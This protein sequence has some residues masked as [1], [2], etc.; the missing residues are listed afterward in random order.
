MSLHTTRA[1]CCMQWVCGPYL[2]LYLH[3][4]Q[5][6]FSCPFKSY[7]IFAIYCITHW[8]S[9]C[10]TCLHK[11]F[12]KSDLNPKNVIFSFFRSHDFFQPPRTG[13]TTVPRALQSGCELVS[14][15]SAV[16][17][18]RKSVPRDPPRPCPSTSRH[19]AADLGCS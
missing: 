5:S 17:R 6:F 19:S 11:I 16:S 18:R 15:W 1:I 12:Q 8:S 9:P 13:Q 7:L 2:L 4:S 14:L 10:I 3:N